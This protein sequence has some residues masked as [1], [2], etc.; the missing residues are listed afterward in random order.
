MTTEATLTVTKSDG[1][2]FVVVAARLD[3]HA[4]T[5]AL[6]PD[7]ARELARKLYDTADEIDGAVG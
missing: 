4:W 7:D 5:M 3:R 6:E 2:A 1:G